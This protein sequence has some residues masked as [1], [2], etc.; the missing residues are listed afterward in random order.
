MTKIRSTL[1]DH[2]KA[3]VNVEIVDL[4]GDGTKD[5]LTSVSAFGGN[6]G[7]PRWCNALVMLK[8][9]TSR[10]TVRPSLH[11]EQICV[12]TSATL[13]Y[14][15]QPATS[16]LVRRYAGV[17]NFCLKQTKNQSYAHDFTRSVD[18]A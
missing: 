18:R 4:N 14:F 1:I 9:Q 2:S 10:I 5:V 8:L 15:N 6:P 7:G 17:S 11:C 13:V 12:R 3:F 16:T